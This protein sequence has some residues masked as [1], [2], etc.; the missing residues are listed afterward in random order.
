[1]STR[2]ALEAYFIHES[3]E[4]AAQFVARLDA[5]RAEVLREADHLLAYATVLE[6]P[7]PGNAP[8]LQIRRSFG[9]ADRWAI[10]DREGRRW[11]REV[12]W[13][14][15]TG[16]IADDRL[17]DTARFTL[18]EAVPLA[19]QLAET[20]APRLCPPCKRGDCDECMA[21]DHP[22][23]PNLYS[24]YCLQRGPDTKTCPR[25][26]RTGPVELELGDDYGIPGLG[27]NT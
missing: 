26:A 7:R 5:F 2:D 27:G 12:G 1:M 18:A 19:R 23:Q 11:D 3:D 17:R 8:P 22:N 14:P 4:D 20:P 13:A 15:E 10:C 9:T 6:I 21:V 16:G 25:P 24:C